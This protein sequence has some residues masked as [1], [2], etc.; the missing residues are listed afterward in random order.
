MDE[1]EY[2]EFETE[3]EPESGVTKYPQP[4]TLGLEEIA[5]LADLK[6]FTGKSRSAL[7]RE[8]IRDLDAKYSA[9]LNAT[10]DAIIE[11]D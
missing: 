2:S 11:T 3:K 10:H 9:L 7:V 8:A 1:Y 5:I 4:F 6:G